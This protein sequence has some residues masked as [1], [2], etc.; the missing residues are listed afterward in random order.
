[1]FQNRDEGGR[2]LAPLFQGRH[3]T[4]SLVLAIPPGGVP[5]GAA[6]ARELGVELDV[7]LARNLQAPYCSQYAIGVI[8][9]TGE[10]SLNRQAEKLFGVTDEYVAVECDRQLA[11]IAKAQEIYRA[12]RPRA[13]G[14]GRSVILTD[15]GSATAAALLTAL[16]A[17][18][19]QK[20]ESLTVAVP[21]TTP[22]RLRK[23]S[24]GCDAVLCPVCSVKAFSARRFYH[25]FP[26]ITDEQAAAWLRPSGPVATPL[27]TAPIQAR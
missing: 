18:R 15:D 3:L 5:T 10:V 22:T 6:L 13:D 26:P 7:I 4:R 19:L 21:L 2:Q 14:A 24:Q 11:R 20:P 8:T 25:E 17:I 27:A 23:I 1:M 16:Q 9:E 12:A